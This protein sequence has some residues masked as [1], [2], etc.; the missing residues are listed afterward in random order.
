MFADVREIPESIREPVKLGERLNDVV[1]NEE[2]FD[3]SVPWWEQFPK[4]WVIVILCFSAFL[5]CN[6]DRVS[7]TFKL[8]FLSL[9]LDKKKKALLLKSFEN[10]R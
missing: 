2:D 4:R 5:L 1:L 7:L 3:S 10:D 6:M 9:L 8:F